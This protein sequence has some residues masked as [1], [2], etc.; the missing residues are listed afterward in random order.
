[1]IN[2]RIGKFDKL[3][4]SDLTQTFMKQRIESFK[5]SRFIV[6][7]SEATPIG[8]AGVTRSNLHLSLI[9]D[10]LQVGG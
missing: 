9:D 5:I 10:F 7:S 3:F 2:I 6:N 4:H 8:F 1:M